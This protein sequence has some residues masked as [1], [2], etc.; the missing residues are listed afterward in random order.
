LLAIRHL[1]PIDDELRAAARAGLTWLLHLQNADGGIPTFCR[2]WTNLPFDRSGSDLTAHALRAWAAWWFDCP[3]L[4]P[5]M[6]RA[7][8][9][10]IEYL[11]KA[12]RPDG[13]W[14]PLWFG[15]QLARGEANP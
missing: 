7:A 8:R 6:S 11:A 9:R 14:A 15:N 12:Q 5:D 2:G 3:E 4:R 13:S 1:G 10:A